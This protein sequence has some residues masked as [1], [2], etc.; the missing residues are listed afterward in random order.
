MR[1]SV[2]RRLSFSYL[3][4][5][6]LLALFAVALFQ[7]GERLRLSVAGANRSQDIIY[8]LQALLVNLLSVE[9]GARG[10]TLTGD[11]SF[12][13]SYR[14]AVSAIPAQFTA[15][16]PLIGTAEQRERFATLHEIGERERSI[17]QTAIEKRQQDAAENVVSDL[18]RGKATMDAARVL[19]GAMI[20][21]QS[22]LV[23]R[24]HASAIEGTQLTNDILVFGGLVLVGGIFAVAFPTL[25]N[26]RRRL[27]A[28]TDGTRQ[29]GAGELAHRVNI[30]G[31]DE[32][33]E[34]AQAFN[35]M[36]TKLQESNTALDAF[37]YTVSHDLRAPLRAMQGFSTALLEDYGAQLDPQGKDYATR[38]VAA[39]GRMDELIQDLLAY[40]RLSRTDIAMGQLS[41]ELIVEAILQRMSAGITK[42]QAVVDVVRPLPVVH[43]HRQTLQQCLIN[44]VGNALKFTAPG[45]TPQIRIRAEV[46][47]GKAR[48]W[49]E[50]QGIGIATEHQDR[51]F[52]VFE[53]LHGAETY[54][55]TGIGLAI[56]KKG[57]ER[58]EG[59]VGVD[60]VLGGG[61][62]FW[63]ELPLGKTAA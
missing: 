39:A 6:I 34:L 11:G 22:E 37:A 48:I 24:E 55:G 42:R 5:T 40:S 57:A 51:I 8:Q 16:E 47:N 60:S 27:N 18:H 32:I 56:V 14:A 50:D 52:R 61:S 31:N 1:L 19:I 29:L 45:T 36:A 46:L 15:L 17:L 26:L 20:Q 21:E 54:P 10:Y 58:M 25:R 59:R 7:S 38:V 63:L 49:V 43:G 12:L 30:A 2:I 9:S 35:A 44:L 53:R 28:V 33:T 62:R 23:R 13:D 41:L 3:F 4:T